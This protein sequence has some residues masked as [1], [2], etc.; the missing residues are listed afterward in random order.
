VEKNVSS[1]AYVGAGRKMVA[2]VY[3]LGVATG[4]V[5]GNVWSRVVPRLIVESGRKDTPAPVCSGRKD[6][7]T[8]QQG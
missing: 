8:E 7:T 3:V 1:D 4:T 2:I 6:R 5:T